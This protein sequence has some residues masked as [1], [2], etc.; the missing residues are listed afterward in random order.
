MDLITEWSAEE[1]NLPAIRLV[2]QEAEAAA[3]SGGVRSDAAQGEGG[4]LPPCG[5]LPEGFIG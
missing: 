5:D 4:P 2:L 1:L 3:L